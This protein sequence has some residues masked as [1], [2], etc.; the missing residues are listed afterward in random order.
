MTG[1]KPV[2]IGDSAGM[3]EEEFARSRIGIGGSDQAVIYGLSPWNS[4]YGFWAKCCGMKKMMILPDNDYQKKK[5]HILEELVAEVFRRRTGFR[6]INDTGIYHHAD[7]PYLR[8]NLDRIYERTALD[9]DGNPVT[10]RGILEIKTT[11]P[12]NKAVEQYWKKGICPEYYRLQV[13]FYMAVMDLDEAY[14]A[15]MWGFDEKENYVQ[16]R[17]TRNLAEEEE[18][19][20]R[21]RKFWETYVVPRRQPPLSY[22]I[23]PK[24]VIRELREYSGFADPGKPCVVFESSYKTDAEEIEAVEKQISELKK[25]IETLEEMKQR[26]QIPIIAEMGT[27]TEGIIM[28]SGNEPEYYE[29]TYKPRSRSYI[30][31]KRLME[32]NPELVAEY[33][34]IR[35]RDLK[36]AQPQVYEKLVEKKG[37]E[38]RV[39]S[40]RKKKFPASTRKAYMNRIAA[41]NMS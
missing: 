9:K 11:F 28:V 3:S 33:A 39:L 34:N 14:I 37:E 24:E 21:N 38:A 40:I 16:I 23:K 29:I 20:E 35:I 31:A 8:A 13:M 7:Y 12:Q 22:T 10:I 6:V 5:G 17:I 30:S 27:A 19:L 18:M 4:M 32:E 25:E 1:K 36:A 41:L 2:L 15:C 26:L